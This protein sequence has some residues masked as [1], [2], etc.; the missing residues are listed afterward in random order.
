VVSFIAEI[1]LSLWLL[2]MGVKDPKPALAD[3]QK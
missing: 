1:S 3:G 2:I